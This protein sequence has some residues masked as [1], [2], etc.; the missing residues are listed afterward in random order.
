MRTRAPARNRVPRRV[1][2]VRRAPKTRAGVALTMVGSPPHRPATHANGPQPTPH[3]P[4]FIGSAE[5][6]THCAPQA[7]LFEGHAAHRPAVHAGVAPIA[8]AQRSPHL[9]QWVADVR[10]SV[11]QP[12]SERPSQSAKPSAHACTQRPSTHAATPLALAEQTTPQAPQWA[13]ELD[14]SAQRPAQAVSPSGQV[15]P[16][17]ELPPPSVEPGGVLPHE[18]PSPN[19]P[20]AK[21]PTSQTRMSPMLSTRRLSEERGR[22]KRE[23]E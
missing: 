1:T 21:S 14:T 19:T 2:L 20:I 6:S 11:S 8:A 4:Q 12:L 18:Q 22:R 16:P 23:T 9:P 5:T 15:E 17:P 13:G 10:V 7:W 3:P